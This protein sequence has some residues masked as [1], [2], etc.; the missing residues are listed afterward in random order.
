MDDNTKNVAVAVRHQDAGQA[1]QWYETI[2]QTVYSEDGQDWETFKSKFGQEA[3]SHF[4]SGT[5]Q[6]FFQATEAYATDPMA[7]IVDLVNAS[8]DELVLLYQEA[9]GEGQESEGQEG[10]GQEGGDGSGVDPAAWEQFLQQCN[11]VWDG[12]EETWAQFTEW[13]R[14]YAPDEI[15]SAIEDLINYVESSGDKVGALYQYGVTTGQPA[16]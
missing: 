12:A 1:S 16:T 8:T 4:D 10:E 14:Y 5:I 2:K 13:L 6:E 11:G 9:M 15:K 3:A 7:T